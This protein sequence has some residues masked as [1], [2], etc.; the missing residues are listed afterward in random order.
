MTANRL[1]MN[2]AKTELLWQTQHCY[3]RGMIRGESKMR[4]LTDSIYNE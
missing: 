3:A 1:Q 2:P 4:T